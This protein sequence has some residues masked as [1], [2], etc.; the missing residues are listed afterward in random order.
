[1][2]DVNDVNVWSVKNS[3]QS[4]LVGCDNITFCESKLVKKQQQANKQTKTTY[5]FLYCS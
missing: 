4:L 5:K 1:M 3:M 2:C